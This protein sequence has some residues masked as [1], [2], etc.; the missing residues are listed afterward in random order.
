M[1]KVTTDYE[2]QLG[3]SEA[4]LKEVRSAVRHAN[5]VRCSPHLCWQCLV[6]CAPA[7]LG[8]TYRCMRCCGSCA[9]VAVREGVWVQ[10]AAQHEAMAARLR[11][12]LAATDSAP[13]ADNAQ[14]CPAGNACMNADTVT[15]E[16]LLQGSSIPRVRV[17]SGQPRVPKLCT[18]TPSDTR[19]HK[20]YTMYLR[21][22]K[23]TAGL[24]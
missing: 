21:V 16:T 17:F 8:H 18:A 13:A 6:L 24:K 14:V 15:A 4:K 23:P 5:K 1:A 9:G 12:Q 10:A 22:Q 3:V 19:M 7:T 20:W 11:K 2:R